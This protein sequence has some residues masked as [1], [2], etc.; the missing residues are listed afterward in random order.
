MLRKGSKKPHVL[1][2]TLTFA[3]RWSHLV[4]TP[5]PTPRTTRETLGSWNVV[6]KIEDGRWELL[7]VRKSMG[8]IIKCRKQLAEKHDAKDLRVCDEEGRLHM[9]CKVLGDFSP[10]P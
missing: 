9:I 10:V 8:A 7:A 2:P 4:A 3:F 6:R 1:L 5:D